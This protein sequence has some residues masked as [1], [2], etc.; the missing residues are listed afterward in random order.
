MFSTIAI[1]LGLPEQSDAQSLRPDD[2]LVAAIDK[3]VEANGINASEPGVAVLIHQPGKLLFQ[4]GYGMA[5]LKA[6]KPIT[7]RTMFELAS[8]SKTFT[9][10]AVLILHDRGKLSIQDD[11]RSHLPELPEYEKRHPIRIRDLLQHTSGLPDYMDF[12]NVPSRHKAFWVNDDYLDLFAK[13]RDQF[14]LVFPT[15]EKYVYNNTNYLLL[16]SIIE[17][18]GK[19]SFGRFLRDEVFTPAGMEHSFIYEGPRAIPDNPPGYAKAVGYTWRKKKKSGN[20]L[21]AR[22][23]HATKSCSRWGTAASGRIWKTWP[24]GIWPFARENSCNPTPGS[25][26]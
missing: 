24:N 10:T 2:S 20:P 18:V 25:W 9:A 19:R 1:L 23:R 22:R 13:R 4:K 15:G 11:V 8:V 21:G 12:E 7:P 6:E 5:N 17:R 3:L 26:P 16:A 14:P